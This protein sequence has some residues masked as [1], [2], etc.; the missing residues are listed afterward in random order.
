MC[1]G[2]V[3]PIEVECIYICT[4]CNRRYNEADKALA[5]FNGHKKAMEI[6]NQSYFFS[7]SAPTVIT[8]KFDDDTT[9][10][11]RL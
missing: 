10:E 6:L 7:D 5:C 4:K 8:V 3:S 1:D 9:A 2:K 11:Y